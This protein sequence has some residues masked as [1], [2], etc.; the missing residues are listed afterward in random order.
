MSSIKTIRGTSPA[1][2]QSTTI[3]GHLHSQQTSPPLYPSPSQ[4]LLF[5]SSAQPRSVQPSS[6]GKIRR[7]SSCSVDNSSM[8]NVYVRRNLSDFSIDSTKVAQSDAGGTAVP[9]RRTNQLLSNPSFRKHLKWMMEVMGED[10]EGGGKAQSNSLRQSMSASCLCKAS[11]KQELR[12]ADDVTYQTEVEAL[13]HIDTGTVTSDAS[14]NGHTTWHGSELNGVPSL[15]LDLLNNS[16]DGMSTTLPHTA[17]SFSSSAL[18]STR[19]RLP[20]FT[21][22]RSSSQHGSL[23]ARPSC[24]ITEEVNVPVREGHGCR[25]YICEGRPRSGTTLRRTAPVVRRPSALQYS[26]ITNDEQNE[27]RSSDKCITKQLRDEAECDCTS[28]RNM[29]VETGVVDD[30]HGSV[31][32]TNRQAPRVHLK[33]RGAHNKYCE[34]HTS[35]PVKLSQSVTNNVDLCANDTLTPCNHTNKLISDTR[36]KEVEGDVNNSDLYTSVVPSEEPVYCNVDYVDVGAGDSPTGVRGDGRKERGLHDIDQLDKLKQRFLHACEKNYSDDH[37]F[38]SSEQNSVTENNDGK[39]FV[40]KSKRRTRNKLKPSDGK[41]DMCKQDFYHTVVCD[42]KCVE[43]V[44]TVNIS[45]QVLAQKL[46]SDMMFSNVEKSRSVGNGS[47]AKSRSYVTS[48]RGRYVCEGGVH[49]SGT[50]GYGMQ[51][52]SESMCNNQVIYRKARCG[53]NDYNK[54][55]KQ[56]GKSGINI[57][58]CHKTTDNDHPRISV[59]SSKYLTETVHKKQE[60]N[61]NGQKVLGQKSEHVESQQKPRHHHKLKP[62]KDEPGRSRALDRSFV[63]DSEVERQTE[64]YNR[65]CKGVHR[66]KS[67]P[68]KNK[69]SSARNKLNLNQTVDH[70]SLLNRGCLSARESRIVSEIPVRPPRRKR[71]AKLALL[72]GLAENEDVQLELLRGEISRVLPHANGPQI[73]IKTEGVYV[74]QCMSEHNV[75][76]IDLTVTQAT[77]TEDT[78]IS[79]EELERLQAQKRYRREYRKKK[80]RS[81]SE[82]LGAPLQHRASRSKERVS[83]HNVSD[84]A[85]GQY[86]AVSVKRTS[87]EQCYPRLYYYFIS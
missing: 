27:R 72:K 11:I 86:N 24:S 8:K 22:Y 2:P 73:P 67:L 87:K 69:V 32:H 5:L 7:G 35:Q 48:H 75:S 6:R 68:D 71:A 40:Y 50:G 74:S 15:D 30:R 19:F 82:G 66:T 63:E 31:D 65:T 9:M 42:R 57:D 55:L 25:G 51:F 54:D 12:A 60:N 33:L 61:H 4:Q 59:E 81:K 3:M 20:S 64:E 38:R 78:H 10:D 28:R 45:D 14:H 53:E 79:K 58:N 23:S 13:S 83:A 85:V 18:R 84:S 46:S 43:N 76:C 52:S 56:L 44:D 41:Q 49:H 39:R 17:R 21:E 37:V 62:Q 26:L 77:P 29:V 36:V 34:S 47:G 16:P 70:G 1:Q 80:R